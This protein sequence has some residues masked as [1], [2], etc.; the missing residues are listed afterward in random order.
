MS[1]SK[2]VKVFYC[3]SD[4][5]KDV[6]LRQKLE[7]H[8]K[9]LERQRVIISW[10][11]GMI[12]PGKERAAEIDRQ[13]N[14]AD[15]ILVLIS[16]DLIAA[17]DHWEFVTKQAMQRHRSGQAR[18]IPILLRPVFNIWKPALDNLTA[19]P[20]LLER[21]KAVTDWGQHDKAFENIA[22]GIKKVAQ[23]L[24]D[25]TFH[26][27]HY[28]QQTGVVVISVVQATCNFLIHIVRSTLFSVFKPS[29]TRRHRRASK[30]A[31]QIVI[32]IAVC[33]VLISLFFW[34]AGIYKSFLL[35]S[36]P[37]IE[38]TEN[39]NYSGWI[40]L[41]IVK[42]H[43]GALS[44]GEPLVVEQKNI[45]EYPSI[46]PLVFPSPGAIVTVKQLVDL[47]QEKSLISEPIHRFQGGEKLVILKVEPLKKASRNS[48]YIR[49]MA[50]VRCHHNC[51]KK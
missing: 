35:I 33:S 34:Q 30:R 29:R 23:E 46:D 15:I 4:S 28:S 9:I 38:S 3:C 24:T 25:P 45:A 8:L 40:W 32:L 10:H 11:R 1:G 5:A 16:S 49:L 14:T 39:I 37:T 22:Q 26:I 18:V 6:Q 51:E 17:D 36:N 7:N 21:E 13:L 50:K 19:L 27:K 48:V 41:G 12:S 43:P 47:R 2:L 31:N 20:T 42:N 44:P